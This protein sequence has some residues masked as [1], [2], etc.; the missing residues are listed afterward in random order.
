VVE[1]TKISEA[2]AVMMV[3]ESAGADPDPDLGTVRR[4]LAAVTAK[5]VPAAVTASV[6]GH[7]TVSA[8]RGQDP[9]HVTAEGKRGKKEMEK[10]EL[11]LRMNQ[12]TKDTTLRSAKLATQPTMATFKL[13]KK[14]SRIFSTLH[15]EVICILVFKNIP[16]TKYLFNDKD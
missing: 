15:S 3:E 6:A 2:P 11:M 1:R 8:A 13:S 5:D 12:L 9:D 4:D 7:V 16:T 14:K 10:M